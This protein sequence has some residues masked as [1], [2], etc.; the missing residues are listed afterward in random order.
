MSGHVVPVPR[1]QASARGTRRHAL[2]NLIYRLAIPCASVVDGDDGE[3]CRR[4][5]AIVRGI[6][7][8][9]C[10]ASE[11]L[12][13]RGGVEVVDGV[14]RSDGLALGSWA[15]HSLSRVA[16]T[17]ITRVDVPG[18]GL[19]GIPHMRVC[20]ITRQ[21]A[22]SQSSSKATDTVSGHVCRSGPPGQHH[23][24]RLLPAWTPP[25]LGSN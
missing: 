23:H 12:I 9:H 5:R 7:Y 10:C 22:W 13:L 19:G 25:Q 3:V 24:Q 18:I 1:T 11:P 8:S 4:H 16:T 6:R 20:T 15:L 21:L 2:G 14:K 17:H